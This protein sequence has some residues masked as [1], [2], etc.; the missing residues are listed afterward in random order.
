MTA[1]TLSYLIAAS[2]ILLVLVAMKKVVKAGK[3]VL[4][5][6]AGFL[7]EI[8]GIVVA[9]CSLVKAIRELIELCKRK[10]R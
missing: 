10:G 8:T 3:D 6:I 2:E 4:H 5:V 7:N 1:F 9:A